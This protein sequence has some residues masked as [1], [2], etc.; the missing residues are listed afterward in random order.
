MLIRGSGKFQAMP[1]SRPRRVCAVFVLGGIILAAAFVGALSAG[2]LP[3]EAGP[4]TEHERRS[5]MVSEELA[6]AWSAYYAEEY[7][8]GARLAEELN[9]LSSSE[10]F[11]WAALQGAHIRAR[12][13]WGGGGS[14]GRRQAIRL[15]QS[16]AES[17]TLTSVRQRSQI[18]EALQLA[19]DFDPAK[20]P[21]AQPDFEHAIELLEEI[22]EDNRPHTTTPEAAID[23]AR[24][25]V[26]VGRFGDAEHTLDFAVRL[27]RR[28]RTP[29]AGVSARRRTRGVRG[30]RAAPPPGRVRIGGR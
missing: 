4:L 2:E 22:L 12:C 10:Y 16:L 15:W 18:A 3:D 26:K 13:L 9:R 24:L 23:L 29:A 17:S 25:Y 21:G 28:G 19:A 30:G 14:E 1:R 20:P 27:M 11:R 6:N 5:L 8:E 7:Q